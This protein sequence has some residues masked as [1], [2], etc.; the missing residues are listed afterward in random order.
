MRINVNAVVNENLK[1]QHSEKL[2]M[3]WDDETP[4][5]GF[6]M[7]PQECWIWKGMEV[8]GCTRKSVGHKIINGYSYSIMGFDKDTVTL[9]VFPE[10][11]KNMPKEKDDEE[12]EEEEGEEGEGEGEGNK[13]ESAVK[14]VD[15][16][17]SHTMFMKHFRLAFAL[18]VCY[19]QGR[20]YR[21]KKVLIM[22]T[23]SEH[24]TMRHLIVAVSRVTNGKDLWIAPPG[25]GSVMNDLAKTIKNA[26][27]AQHA[28]YQPAEENL[29]TWCISWTER[30]E[31]RPRRIVRRTARDDEEDA[32]DA[33]LM[34]EDSD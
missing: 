5:P 10:F 26:R 21:N 30:Q 1:D 32:A 18:P 25:F 19:A 13:S 23:E 4:L 12:E 34:E 24:F 17:I 20:T 3:P 15:F 33:R 27:K 14:Q 2:W 29:M 9:Q 7:Q 22:N 8:I 11:A 6:T 31:N 16:Q 28:P